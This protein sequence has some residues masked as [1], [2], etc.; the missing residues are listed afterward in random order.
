MRRH[1]PDRSAVGNGLVDREVEPVVSPVGLGPVERALPAGDGESPA[2]GALPGLVVSTL[3]IEQ[4]LDACVGRG[5]EHL[6]PAR[7]GAPSA[8]GFFAPAV[9][10]RSLL[11]GARAVEDRA[12][13]PHQLLP[14]RMPRLAFADGWGASAL[15]QPTTACFVPFETISSNSARISSDETTITFGE[16][17]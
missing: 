5:L 3:F 17:I 15:V 16:R 10:L 11:L 9:D 7:S 6:G 2:G 14:P 1:C 4:D 13:Q 8:A 12:R